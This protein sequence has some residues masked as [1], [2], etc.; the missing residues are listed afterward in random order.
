MAI[1]KRA[2]TS[3][4]ASIDDSSTC[5][6][7]RE[8]VTTYVRQADEYS[9]QSFLERIDTFRWVDLDRSM[10]TIAKTFAYIRRLVNVFHEGE[11]IHYKYCVRDLQRRYL[12]SFNSRRQIHLLPEYNEPCQACSPLVIENETTVEDIIAN[13]QTYCVDIMYRFLELFPGTPVSRNDLSEWLRQY[14]G[15]DRK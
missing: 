14:T 6:R 15:E 12:F 2:L 11:S 9:A 7:I 4:A 5:K 8:H 13:W 1:P 10:E 3:K